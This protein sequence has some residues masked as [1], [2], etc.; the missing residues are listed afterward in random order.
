[1]T[2]TALAMSG[3]EPMLSRNEQLTRDFF[4]AWERADEAAIVGFFADDAVYH[5]IPFKPVSGVDSI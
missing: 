3:N 4:A 5:N 1:M 2:N